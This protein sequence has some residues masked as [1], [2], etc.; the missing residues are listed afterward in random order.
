MQATLGHDQEMLLTQA[1]EYFLSNTKSDYALD[2]SPVDFGRT[3]STYAPPSVSLL[4]TASITSLQSSSLSRAASTD[5]GDLFTVFDDVSNQLAHVLFEAEETTRSALRTTALQL[6]DVSLMEFDA[7]GTMLRI[8]EGCVLFLQL[9]LPLGSLV[10]NEDVERGDVMNVCTPLPPPP[11]AAAFLWRGLSCSTRPR[12]N[13]VPSQ[14][15][16][17]QRVSVAVVQVL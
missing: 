6:L 16:A 10:H 11:P 14:A 5:A 7:M 2:F 8:G 12:A 15:T 13:G 17:E 9:L 4:R 3:P 1:T